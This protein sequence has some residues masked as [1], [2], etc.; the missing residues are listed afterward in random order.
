MENCTGNHLDRTY[1]HGQK[2]TKM[3]ERHQVWSDNHAKVSNFLGKLYQSWSNLLSR[4]E[5]E[6]IL[7][8]VILLLAY[9]FDC[10]APNLFVHPISESGQAQLDSAKVS[11]GGQAG[12]VPLV[13]N[14][15]KEIYCDCEARKASLVHSELRGLCNC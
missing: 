8:D 6:A 11:L 9:Y 2:N 12:D 14:V 1:S 5:E 10:K 7:D 15:Y 13:T 3:A 4:I